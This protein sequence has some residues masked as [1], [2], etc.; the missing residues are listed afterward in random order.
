MGVTPV[1][2]CVPGP[3]VTLREHGFEVPGSD[4][5]ANRSGIVTFTPHSPRQLHERLTTA[6]FALSHPDGRLWQAT[7][8]CASMDE[9]E[10]P[11]AEAA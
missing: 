11:P 7:H 1:A 3:A 8:F 6:G 5:D 4:Q 9:I 10:V 2:E